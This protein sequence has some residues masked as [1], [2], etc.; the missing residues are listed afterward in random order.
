VSG[1]SS[2]PARPRSAPKAAVSLRDAPWSRRTVSVS[3][4]RPRVIIVRCRLMRSSAVV[5]WAR[6]VES[7]GHLRPLWTRGT[8]VGDRTGAT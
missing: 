1:P 8:S 2:A 4:G 3:T 6:R 5:V 7:F